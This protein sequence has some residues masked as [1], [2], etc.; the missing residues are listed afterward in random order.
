MKY[1]KLVRD[2]IP[3][4][5]ARRGDKSVTRILDA[6]AYE[7]ELRSKLQEEVAEFG[8]SGEVEELVDILEVVYALAAVKDVSRFQLEEM[9]ARKQEKKGGFDQRIFL[10]ETSSEGE[11]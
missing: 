4:I 8:A 2:K 11:R 5:I 10:I 7:R 6:D 9:R 3:D 1:D